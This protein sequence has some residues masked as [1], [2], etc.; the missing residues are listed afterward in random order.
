MSDLV[1][2]DHIERIVGARRHILDHIGRAVS[3]EQTVYIL[4]SQWCL[5]LGGDPRKCPY[6]LALDRGIN[7]AEWAGFEDQ[8]VKL[9]I[10]VKTLRLMPARIAT[11]VHPPASGREI[12]EQSNG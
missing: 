3:A 7:V 12:G 11:N 5:N 4:H 9:W 8:P 2:T 6:S 1:P 10:R